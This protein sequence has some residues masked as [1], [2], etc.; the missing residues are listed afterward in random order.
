MLKTVVV[1]NSK[2][3]YWFKDNKASRTAVFIHGLCGDYRGLVECSHYLNTVNVIILN[4]PGF[5]YS[6]P[7]LNMAHNLDGY[8]NFILDFIEKLELEEIDLIG[9]SFGASVSLTFFVKFPNKL[10]KLVLISPIISESKTLSYRLAKGYFK[11]AS[12]FN[13]RIFHFLICNRVIVYISDILIMTKSSKTIRHQILK[14][15]YQ[16]YRLAN[17]KTIRESF[18]AI[19]LEKIQLI[20]PNSI[21]VLAI[22]GE[23]D[24]LSSKDNIKLLNKLPNVEIQILGG[25]HLVNQEEPKLVG[26]TITKFLN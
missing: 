13:D 22:V 26:E 21:A 2:T 15:D 3:T 20:N 23:Q 16:N 10:N 1:N 9:H 24:I 8:A 4:L 12:I 11:F 5:G 18:Y 14:E 17:A 7:L 19:D 6:E 25:G